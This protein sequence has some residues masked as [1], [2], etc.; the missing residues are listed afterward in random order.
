MSRVRV[1]TQGSLVVVCGS[2][3]Q[4]SGRSKRPGFEDSCSCTGCTRRSRVVGRVTD[5]V[6]P[7][8]H[9][10]KN[11]ISV[12][13]FWNLLLVPILYSYFRTFS[14]SFLLTY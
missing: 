8:D 3:D 6:V 5:R 2:R 14:F 9:F 11:S 13:P 4:T 12:F 10:T 7:I 1:N